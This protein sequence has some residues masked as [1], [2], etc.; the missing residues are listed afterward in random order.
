MNTFGTKFIII[1]DIVQPVPGL[2]IGNPP[3]RVIHHAT[4][5][6]GF[7]EY[8]VLASATSEKLYLNKVERNRATFVLQ[9]IEDDEEYKDL[10]AFLTASGIFNMGGPKKYGN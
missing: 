2:A 3:E 7:Q 9:A 1:S 4:I 6:R 8:V 5:K 10:V